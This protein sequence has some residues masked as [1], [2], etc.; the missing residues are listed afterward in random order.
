MYVLIATGVGAA[1]IAVVLTLIVRGIG[2]AAG[3]MDKPD[4]FRKVNPRQLPRLGGVAIFFAVFGA[5]AGAAAFSGPGVIRDYLFT[6]DFLTLFLG[7]AG[8]MIVGLLDDIYSVR[9]RYKLILLTLVAAGVYFGGH[10]ITELTNPLGGSFE[11]GL[12]G[13]VVTVFW[14]LACMNAV[15]LIDGLDG[16]ASGVAFFAVATLLVTGFT[17]N[18]TS[19]VL[20]SV[21][22][23]G[24]LV[25]FLYFNFYPASIFLGDSGSYLL[26]FLIAFIGSST[27]QKSN[28]VVALLIPII[29]LG[30]PI[31]DS[32]LAILRRWAKRLP[33][34]AA[35]RQHIHHRLLDMGLSHRQAVLALYLGCVILAAFALT[36][37]VTKGAASLWVLLGLG[38]FFVLVM[39]TLGRIELELLRERFFGLMDSGRRDGEIRKAGFEAVERFRRAADLPALWDV[40]HTVAE[41]LELD[42]VEV[43]LR[44]G[45]E[46]Y[47]WT[48]PNDPAESPPD[49]TWRAAITLKTDDLLW[50]EVVFVKSTRGGPLSSQLPEIS[51]LIA[52]ALAANLRRLNQG[53]PSDDN[54]AA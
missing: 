27:A 39:N 12:A 8:A 53:E 38:A 54:A 9:A 22:L 50:G 43:T 30:V 24:A 2:R 36:M 5:M 42:S 33:I 28:T 21:A 13:F 51:T 4:G 6:R 47:A 46:P 31:F 26:G 18:Q 1:A 29:A 7:A 3:V 35:D 44:S 52:N 48:R 40:L 15:N 32:T 41:R 17:I 16:L 19:G 37:N 34:S 20:L 11:L 25:G 14:F 10:R 45:G 49:A 23:L